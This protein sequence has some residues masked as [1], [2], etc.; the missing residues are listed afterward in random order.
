MFWAKNKYSA[1]KLKAKANIY[2][3][4]PEAGFKKF[5]LKRRKNPDPKLEL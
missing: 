5:I 2:S 4:L 1:I 3:S